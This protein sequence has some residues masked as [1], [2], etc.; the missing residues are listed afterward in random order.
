VYGGVEV[1]LPARVGKGWVFNNVGVG[2]RDA[3]V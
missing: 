2:Y 3:A 1:R